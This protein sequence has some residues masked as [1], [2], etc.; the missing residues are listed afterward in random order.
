MSVQFSYELTGSGWSECTLR[1]DGHVASVTASYLSDALADLASATAA[2]LRGHP[3]AVASF[4]EE[5]GEYR[6]IL[7]PRPAGRV[8][9]RVLEFPEFWGHE[10][11]EKGSVLLDAECRLRTFAGAVVSEL[12]RLLAQFGREGYKDRWI[13]HDFPFDQM[14]AIQEL[15]RNTPSDIQ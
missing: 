4:A 10:P 1:I 14:V 13:E 2:A 12:Q 7:E 6:W 9:I 8:R 11:D 15:L 3:R 5:P